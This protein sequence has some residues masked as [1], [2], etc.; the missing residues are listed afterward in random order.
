M[1]QQQPMNL[2]GAAKVTRR[3]KYLVGVLTLI[4][5]LLGVGYALVTPPKLSSQAIVVLPKP[6]PNI[7][8]QVLIAG[9]DP[10]LTGALASLGSNDSLQSLK[11]SISVAEDTP[12]AISFIAKANTAAEAENEANS[13]AAS[14]ISY[15]TSDRS[16]VAVNQA[17]ILVNGTTATGKSKLDNIL[18]DGGIGLLAGLV[19]GLIAAAARDRGNPRLRQRGQIARAAG[20]P[21]LAGLAGGSPAG[22][23]RAKKSWNARTWAKFFSEFE[24]LGGSTWQLRGVLDRLTAAGTGPSDLVTVVSAASDRGALTLGA[25]LAAFAAKTGT[26]TALVV[27]PQA[28]PADASGLRSIAAAG[29]KSGN[30]MVRA[31]DPA[32]EDW[33]Q[34]DAEL[35]VVI[36]TVAD[37]TPAVPEVAGTGPTLLAVTAGALSGPEL[38][39]V[40]AAV[41]RTGAVITGVIVGDP[42][43]DDQTTGRAPAPGAAR[44][45]RV[46]LNGTKANGLNGQVTEMR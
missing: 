24:P 13:V 16:P 5:I 4:G 28:P 18:I 36:V 11:K 43:E 19:I 40:A 33:S 29:G 39:R 27:G 23:G 10:V 38:A 22:R 45:P 34:E 44:G 26:P 17:N 8:T 31:A 14:Y 37:A 20:A 3:Y 42:E 9:S 12:N 46:K 41:R 15:T 30:L 7:Q 25:K 32:A 6:I 21:V 1:N 2:R 35:N